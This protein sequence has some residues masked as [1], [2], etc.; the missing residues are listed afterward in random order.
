MAFVKGWPM[1]AMTTFASNGGSAPG[2]LSTATGS[3]TRGVLVIQEWWGLDDHIKDVAERLAARGFHALAP[4]LYHGAVTRSPDEASKLLMALD[5][6]RAEK[7]LRGAASHLRGITGKP[8]GTVGFCMGGALS[9]F[10]ACTNPETVAACVVFYGG[11]P[12]VSYDFDRLRAPVL[13]HWAEND[14]FANQSRDR[15]AVALQ[16]RRKRFEFHTYVGTRHAFFNDT[17]REVHAKD[18]AELA[19]A[20]TIDFLEREL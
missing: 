20:R 16:E 19:F 4:D 18:A 12:S 1:G 14:T 10:A 11:H 7:D 2:Y 17:R 8:V 3:S 5:V 15:V 13:G 9:L 6:A